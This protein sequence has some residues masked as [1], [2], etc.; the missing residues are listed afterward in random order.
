VYIIGIN[1]E[2]RM[3]FAMLCGTRVSLIARKCDMHSSSDDVEIKNIDND[4]R[5]NH[6]LSER[7]LP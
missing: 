1:M 2:I 3:A 7:L 4:K 5:V 6:P